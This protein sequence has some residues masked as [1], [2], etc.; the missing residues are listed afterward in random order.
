M[1]L[2]GQLEA[3][4]TAAVAAVTM[5]EAATVEMIMG[6]EDVP[7]AGEDAAEVDTVAAAQALRAEVCPDPH[8]HVVTYSP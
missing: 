7:A 5:A 6:K 4:P 2:Y 8:P 1:A 3:H